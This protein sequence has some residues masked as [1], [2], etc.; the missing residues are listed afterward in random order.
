M[1]REFQISIFF[2]ILQIFFMEQGCLRFSIILRIVG[3]G[4][5]GDGSGS[6]GRNPDGIAWFDDPGGIVVSDSI[7]RVGKD[8]MGWD[9]FPNG[10]PA[11]PDGISVAVKDRYSACSNGAGDTVYLLPVYDFIQSDLL[12]GDFMGIVPAFRMLL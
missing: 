8:G 1:L 5:I 12:F 2:G 7:S 10:K 9:G 3:M 4:V 6:V 11:V